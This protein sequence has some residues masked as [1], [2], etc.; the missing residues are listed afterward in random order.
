MNQGS[1]GLKDCLFN[2]KSNHVGEIPPSIS[3]EIKKKGNFACHNGLQLPVAQLLSL[4]HHIK[5]IC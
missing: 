5:I 2:V 4:L 3:Y 1:D